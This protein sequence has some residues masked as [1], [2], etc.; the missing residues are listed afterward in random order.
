MS[1][2]RVNYLSESE[3]NEILDVWAFGSRIATINADVKLRYSSRRQAIRALEDIANM[4]DIKANRIYYKLQNAV[5]NPNG[6]PYLAGRGEIDRAA[7][8][9]LRI[10]VDLIT[11][12]GEAHETHCWIE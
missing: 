11:G 8:R 12:V 7:N 6:H 5:S 4:E 1:V 2:S 3:I 9:C 10:E